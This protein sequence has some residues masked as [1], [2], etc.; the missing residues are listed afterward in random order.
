MCNALGTIPPRLAPIV[1]VVT[2]LL[3]PTHA[4]CSTYKV[5]APSPPLIAWIALLAI[6]D[7]ELAVTNVVNVP[8]TFKFLPIPAPP[9]TVNAPVVVDVDCVKPGTAKVCTEKPPLT[10]KSLFTVT[11]VPA[12]SNV[13]SPDKLEIVPPA[14]LKLPTEMLVG[15][16][17]ALFVPS[18]IVN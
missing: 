6:V 14:K 3:G 2:T 10:C 11:S 12:G 1:A 9:P 17:V 7:V 4:S 5:L 13:I 18:V 16:I 15:R 8:P